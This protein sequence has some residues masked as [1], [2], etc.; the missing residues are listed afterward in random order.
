MPKPRGLCL[1]G[2]GLVRNN[3]LLFGYFNPE[4]IRAKR[5]RTSIELSLRISDPSASIPKPGGREAQR[6]TS[7][8]EV[9]RLP[10][11]VAICPA[12]RHATSLIGITQNRTE[13]QV[14]MG[15]HRGESPG[16]IKH[17]PRSGGCPTRRGP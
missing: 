11:L 5:S 10:R 13:D 6:S 3:L 9:C 4:I 12:V 16:S 7:R 14:P 17:E 15:V 8:W 2:G 1:F